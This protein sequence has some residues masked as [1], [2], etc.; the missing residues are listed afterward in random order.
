MIFVDT[1]AWA[2]AELGESPAAEACRAALAESTGELVTST[3][4]LTEL[5]TLL[6]VR[7]HPAR[8]SEAC[9]DVAASCA[10]L[11]IGRRDHER[12]LAVLRAWADASF[13]YG[14]ATSFV[15]ME[16]E[17]IEEALALDAHFRVYRYGPSRRRAFVVRP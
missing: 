4:V 7:R 15:L 12:A 14:D 8:A 13:S 5:W 16:R 11:E 3:S 10:V 9:L 2:A 17:G 6:A 1:G